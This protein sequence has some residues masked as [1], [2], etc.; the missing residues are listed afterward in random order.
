MPAFDSTRLIRLVSGLQLK[1]DISVNSGFDLRA[2]HKIRQTSKDFVRSPI[3]GKLKSVSINRSTRLSVVTNQMFDGLLEHFSLGCDTVYGVLP[4]VVDGN[5]KS[6]V[7]RV[8]EDLFYNVSI[9]K[10]R[11]VVR[12]RYK[13]ALNEERGV[14]SIR[15]F[16]APYEMELRLSDSSD[17]RKYRGDIVAV[18]PQT[19]IGVLT[20]FCVSRYSPLEVHLAVLPWF[21]PYNGEFIVIV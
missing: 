15:C 11:S 20:H 5:E 8:R 13:L 1:G 7:V 14:I 19:E 16:I 12:L 18:D 3:L 2:I 21:A 4:D 9:D 6:F 10:S 17:R